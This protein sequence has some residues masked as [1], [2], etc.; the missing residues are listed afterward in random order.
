[1]A[2]ARKRTRYHGPRV[3]VAQ[4]AGMRAWATSESRDTRWLTGWSQLLAPH[5][6]SHARAEGRSY[7]LTGPKWGVAAQLAFLSLFL[8]CFFFLSFL[9]PNLNSNVVVKFMLK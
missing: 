8:L 2:H 6:W 9:N 5:F 3:V 4:T 1:V 7:G